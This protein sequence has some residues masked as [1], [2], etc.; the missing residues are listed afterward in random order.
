MTPRRCPSIIRIDV[1]FLCGS[2]SSMWVRTKERKREWERGRE[3]IDRFL[4]FF[5]WQPSRD[6]RRWHARSLAIYR[7]KQRGRRN[8]GE[9]EK[10]KR[11]ERSEQSRHA[12]TVFF[13]R[14]RDFYL[15]NAKRRPVGELP[16][17]QGRRKGMSQEP[18]ERASETER[19]RT[20]ERGTCV[21]VKIFRYI[22]L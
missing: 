10:G 6:R 12:R 7:A 3:G 18:S 19:E 20:K 4:P 9:K 13:I 16:A 1:D 11:T 8:S 5:A 22:T 17:G 21:G 15:L 14:A 2:V